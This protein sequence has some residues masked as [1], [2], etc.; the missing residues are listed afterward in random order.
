LFS[1]WIADTFGAGLILYGGRARKLIFKIKF[2]GPMLE[3]LTKGQFPIMA[4]LVTLLL[5]EAYGKPR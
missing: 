5:S 1:F 2:I 4:I 3:K